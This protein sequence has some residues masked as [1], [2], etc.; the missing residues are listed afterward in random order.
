MSAPLQCV[1]RTFTPSASSSFTRI[2]TP[3][4]VARRRHVDCS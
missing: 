4:L 3:I 1:Y 2:E